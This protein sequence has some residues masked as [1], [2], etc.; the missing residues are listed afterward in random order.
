MSYKII[1][2]GIFPYV[3]MGAFEVH[4]M[5]NLDLI[6]SEMDFF[7]TTGNICSYKRTDI[8][9]KDLVSLIRDGEIFSQLTS[10]DL[11]TIIEQN[12]NKLL[13]FIENHE[14]YMRG[15]VYPDYESIEG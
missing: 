3:K 11:S 15:P 8:P 6:N 4:V 14:E 5:T 2:G 1:S 13:H 9:Q 10:A 12:Q 7:I